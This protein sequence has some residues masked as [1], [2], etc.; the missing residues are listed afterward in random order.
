MQPFGAY[1]DGDLT[2]SRLSWRAILYYLYTG[3]I[4]FGRLDSQPLAST[5]EGAFENEG[6]GHQL[7]SFQLFPTSPKSVYTLACTVR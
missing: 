5:E 1:D 3:K 2:I 6:G 4:T 7:E